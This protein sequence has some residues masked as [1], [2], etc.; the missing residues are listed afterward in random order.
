MNDLTRNSEAELAD[1]TVQIVALSLFIV[2]VLFVLQIVEYFVDDPLANLIDWTT[3][4]LAVGIVALT[5]G[6]LA[7]KFRGMSRV[8]RREYLSEDG[9]L[10]IGF[11]RAMAKSW[12]LSFVVLV[13]LQSLDRLVL[14]PLPELPLKLV[15]QAILAIM[16]GIFSIAFLLL[17]RS[18]PD[19]D[20]EEVSG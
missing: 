4:F 7:L 1:R 20:W 6:M 11:Q 8:Q 10:Q 3:R 9:F 2:A 5:V 16:L 18:E 14:E 19:T 17:T 15:I 13:V 12:M